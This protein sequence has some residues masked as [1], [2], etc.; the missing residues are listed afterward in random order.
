[1]AA[2]YTLPERTGLVMAMTR[3]EL[4]LALPGLT[5]GPG[6]RRMRLIGAEAFLYL[7]PILEL[8]RTRDRQFRAGLTSNTFRHVRELSDARS[9]LVTTPNNDTLYSS[10]WLDLSHD[11]VVELPATGG[12][13]LSIALMDAF[14]NNVQVVRAHPN[15]PVS[16]PLSRYVDGRAGSRWVWAL[17][18][19]F[20]KGGDDSEA[21][22]ALQ[23]EIRIV[24]AGPPSGDP[25]TGRL[26]NRADVGAVFASAGALLSEV[27]PPPADS[28]AVARFR[29]IAVGRGLSYPGKLSAS[30]QAAVGDG[31]RQALSG[32][33]FGDGELK[34]GW[35]FPRSAL[36]HFGT[37][38]AYRASVA[39]TGLGALPLSEALYLKAAGPEGDGVYD[40]RRTYQIRFAP[41][42][43][44]PVDAFWSLSLYEVTPE[45]QLFFFDN[46]LNRYAVGTDPAQLH[47]EDDG[48]IVITM[49]A[50][51][52]LG[53]KNWLPAPQ[54]RFALQLRAFRPKQTL[55]DGRYVPPP[56]IEV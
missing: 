8:A 1:M 52:P 46:P 45:G 38:Y 47:K 37:D 17:G 51:R 35:L 40:G 20:S 41:G 56:V 14:S 22:R 19:T 13:Y 9:R 7:L 49:A 6:A 48:G 5:S 55:I 18:R 21:A 28:A 30:D 54:G 26:P 29:R 43:L 10:A 12:R 25:G 50:V 39:L 24:L 4:L 34:G 42:R 15:R 27:T 11:A 33:K 3:R 16:A 31:A 44:P 23:D 36:G 53:A 32:L 2:L